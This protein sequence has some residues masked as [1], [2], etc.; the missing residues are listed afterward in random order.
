MAIV[1][2]KVQASITITPT[3]I[4]W[5]NSARSSVRLRPDRPGKLLWWIA[6]RHRVRESKEP[7][8]DQE[9]EGHDP[10]ALTHVP[11][12]A[13]RSVRAALI[14]LDRELHHYL[15]HVEQNSKNRP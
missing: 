15:E 3:T 10:E 12:L 11:Y 7:F 2:I 6:V 14:K 5:P 1:V 13:D 9:E 8:K 4:G